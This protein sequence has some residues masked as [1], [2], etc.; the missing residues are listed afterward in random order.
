MSSPPQWVPKPGEGPPDWMMQAG[1]YKLYA[2]ASEGP[3]GNKSCYAMHGAGDPGYSSTAKMA[4][5][6]ALGLS[7][8]G[9]GRKAMVG[10]LTPSL[11]L[12]TN[13]LRK[14]LERKNINGSHASF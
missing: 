2:V 9:S 5:E 11:A 13:V 7:K 3:N 10:F 14:R 4:T 1:S 6:L 12:G 8:Q